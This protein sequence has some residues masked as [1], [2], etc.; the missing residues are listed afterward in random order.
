MHEYVYERV[1]ECVCVH[2]GT[3][4]QKVNCWHQLHPP[5]PMLVPK[6]ELRTLDFA[7]SDL[8]P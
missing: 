3:G 5:H 8:A 7:A 1:S 4:S 2:V 6:T